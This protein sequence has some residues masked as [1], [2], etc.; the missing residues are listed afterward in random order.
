MNRI[1]KVV[2]S[3]TR[4]D[5]ETW[6]NSTLLTGDVI[7][8]L[9][10]LRE[11]GDVIVAG[12]VDLVRALTEKNLVDEYRLLVFPTVLGAGRRLFGPGTPPADLRLLSV[13]QSGAAV[14]MRHER[15]R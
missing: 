6:S 12:S 13:E 14:L 7:G 4:P 8:E 9:P 1:P 11:G 10:R 15:N 3:R 2:A 5:L